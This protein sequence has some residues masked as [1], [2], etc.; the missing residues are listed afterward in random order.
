MK[1]FEDKTSVITGGASGIG[2]AIAKL[3]SEKKMNVV[4]ADIEKEA[5]KT[6]VKYFEDRQINVLGVQID[7][8]N[9]KS[10]ENLFNETKERFGKIHLLFNN[11]GVVNGGSPTPI[12]ELP[13]QDWDWVMGVNLM[14]VLNGI[15]T[16]TPHMIEHG[17][18][19]HIVNTASIAAFIPGAG[20]YGV[21][22]SGV[23]MLSET[24]ALDLKKIN[25]KIGASVICPGWV[26]T[27]ISDAERNRPK[28]LDSPSN[29]DRIGLGMNKILEAG[30]SPEKLAEQVFKAIEGNSFYI[31][32]HQ[33]WDY[34]LREHTE[35]MLRR[36]G[37]YVFNTMAHLATRAEGK[38]V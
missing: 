36:E 35:A 7:A 10:L 38:D 22:K 20:P 15:Q 17:E 31:F 28:E 3:C 19:G 25:A 12:W 13:K 14:G 8:K 32:P 23:V 6:S 21:S 34:L 29:P 16:F 5:L 30:K 2:F 1:N 9:K 37:P 18:E 11:A 24:L 4:L 27:K 26:N 33:G